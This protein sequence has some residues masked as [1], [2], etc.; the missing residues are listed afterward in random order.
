MYKSL[1]MCMIMWDSDVFYHYPPV[2]FSG[3]DSNCVQSL[4]SKNIECS[5]DASTRQ[6]KMGGDDTI[7][8]QQYTKNMEI[9]NTLKQRKICLFLVQPTIQILFKMFKNF[10]MEI[11]LIGH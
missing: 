9:T 6:N 8:I 1:D 4:L 10:L 5:H 2:D 7:T 3:S 11:N